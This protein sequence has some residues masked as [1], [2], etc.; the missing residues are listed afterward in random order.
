MKYDVIIIGGGAAGLAAASKLNKVKVLLIE[1]NEGLGRKLLLSG[2]GQCNVTHSGKITAFHKFFGPNGK[3][4]KE[5]LKAYSNEDL[6]EDLQKAG[7]R[8]ITNDNGKV[9]PES[10]DSQDVLDAF[11][12]MLKKN[13]VEI[14]TK[15]SV[16]VVTEDHEGYYVVTDRGNY[17]TENVIVATGGMTYKNTG[18][19]GDGYKFAQALGVELVKPREGLTPVVS[20]GFKLVDLMGLSFED[21]N[22]QQWRGGKK[23]AAYQGDLLITHK[24]ISGPVVLNNS[25]YFKQNDTIK[26][27]FLKLTNEELEK[28]ILRLIGENPKK[29]LKTLLSTFEL[30]SRLIDKL[31]ELAE[32]KPHLKA[33]ELPKEK[34]K[35]LCRL[36]AEYEVPIT[37]FGGEHIAMVTCGGIALGDLNKKTM[38]SKK[39]P[40]IYFV[41]EVVD[42]DGDTGG[43]NLQAAFSMGVAAARAILKKI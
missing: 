10:M 8:C 5:A 30:P 20:K 24:G 40:G 36:F 13:K 26:I 29:E 15:E 17:Q 4:L 18:S 9:F 7:V 31:Y 14:H 27:N 1:K 37:S 6:L 35:Q 19:T 16:K 25:R 2:A 41:G 23:V 32:L 22:L 34:R 42:V 28:E 21:C 12:G 33:S 11:I 38:E 3:F 43:Y 39:H